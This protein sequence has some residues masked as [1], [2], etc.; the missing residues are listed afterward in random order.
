MISKLQVFPLTAEVDNS[1]H[2]YVGGCDCI[3]LVKEFGTPLYIFDEFTLRSKCREFQSEFVSRYPNTLVAYA[4]KS[5]LNRAIAGII[6]EEG[7]GLDVVSGGE[8]SIAGSVDFPPERVFF[9]GNNKTPDEL[10]LALELKTG[11]VVVDSFHEMELL[12]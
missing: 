2:L 12:G 3:E 1:G 4:S 9:H 8:L 11:R 10:S 5:F 6:N 7:L